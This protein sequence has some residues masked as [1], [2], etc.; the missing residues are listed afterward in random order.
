MK[1]TIIKSSLLILLYFP[2]TLMAQRISIKKLLVLQNSS[3][4]D[5]QNFLDTNSWN[6]S[7]TKT[8]AE[9]DSSIWEQKIYKFI[10]SIKHIK[11]KSMSFKENSF[12]SQ[13]IRTDY[14]TPLCLIYYPSDSIEVKGGLILNDFTIFFP[15]H[16]LFEAISFDLNNYYSKLFHIS[17]EIS[18]KGS[19]IKDIIKEIST[20][21]ISKDS[22]FIDYGEKMLQRVYKMKN[23]VITITTYSPESFENKTETYAIAIYSKADYEFLNAAQLNLKGKVDFIQ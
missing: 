9:I 19:E 4:L 15:K 11:V 10:D 22:S 21:N 14:K 18:Y 23:Q 17:I 5:I 6:L 16:A 13:I 7:R 3:L 12:N 1:R 8:L 20:F 2:F